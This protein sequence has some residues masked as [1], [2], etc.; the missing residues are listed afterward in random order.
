MIIS[1]LM[2]WFSDV[3][4]SVLLVARVLAGF[5]EGFYIVMETHLGLISS[6]NW[7]SFGFSMFVVMGQ[8]GNVAVFVGVPR[9]AE[10]SLFI[11]LGLHFFVIVVIIIALITFHVVTYYW[12]EKFGL[13]YKTSIDHTNDFRCSN[14]KEISS[15]FWFVVLI[16]NFCVTPQVIMTPFYPSYLVTLGYTSEE[17]GTMVSIMS[18]M[19]VLSPPLSWIIDKYNSRSFSWLVLITLVGLSF[20]ML[21]LQIAHPLIWMLVVGIAQSNL[22]CT[23]AA[24]ISP[25]V[26]SKLLGTAYGISG[27]IFCLVG[28]L[29]PFVIGF[30]A[31]HGGWF[32][33]FVILFGE[34][35]L[36]FIC[37]IVFFVRDV[38]HNFFVPNE[39]EEIEM[40]T[41]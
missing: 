5:N 39:V 1:G 10:S 40:I 37:G 18:S 19:A 22:S 26:S 3:N 21:A 28:L 25:L 16:L 4:F 6:G 30:L 31:E 23:V 17:A 41:M 11:C 2:T 15:N 14:L 7:L 38:Q 20:V 24:S 9:I 8:I 32:P 29:T 12:N 34:T 13:E 36:G 35:M 27:M 33:V